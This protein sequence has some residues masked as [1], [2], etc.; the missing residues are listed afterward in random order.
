MMTAY[1]SGAAA[2]IVFVEGTDVSFFNADQPFKI[3]KSDI[4]QIS[5]L[6][7]NAGDV[8]RVQVKLRHDA[9]PLLLEK[10]DLDRGLQLLDI[11]LTDDDEVFREEAIDLLEGILKRHKSRIR[12]RDFVLAVENSELPSEDDLASLR[13]RAPNY[14]DFLEEIKRAQVHI[15]RFQLALDRALAAL[16]VSPEESVQFRSMAIERGAF[17]ALVTAGNDERLINQA[18]MLC[19]ERLKDIQQARVIIQAW[20]RDVI[21]RTTRGEMRKLERELEQY[22][23]QGYVPKSASDTQGYEIYRHVRQQQAVIVDKMRQGALR[24]ASRFADQLIRLQVQSGGEAYAAKTLSSLAVEARKLGQRSLELQWA[25]TSVELMPHDGKG[26]GVLADTYL[27]LYRIP[28]AEEAF[29]KSSALGEV[30]FGDVG[31]GRVRKSS[32]RFDEAL[33]IFK[34][35][36]LKFQNR[37][38]PETFMAYADTLREMWRETE[39]LE[40]YKTALN[41]FPSDPALRCGEAAVWADLGEHA[42]AARIYLSVNISYGDYAAAWC[43]LAAVRKSQGEFGAA[44][45]IYTTAKQKFPSNVVAFCGYADTLRAQGNYNEALSAYEE[46]SDRFPFSPSPVSGFADTLKD[47]RR[48]DDALIYL[49]EANEKFPLNARLRNNYANALKLAGFFEESLGHF[50]R[51]ARDFPYDL[52]SLTG[53]AHLLRLLGNYSAAL[54]AY[55]LIIDRRPGYKFASNA[56]ASILVAQ[57]EYGAAI[58]MLELSSPKTEDDWVTL[59]IRGMLA[60][61]CGAIDEAEELLSLGMGCPFFRQRQ[62]FETAYALLKLKQGD[63]AAADKSILSHKDN[64]SVLLHVHILL[65]K[66]E[67]DS[68]RRRYN[69]V[70]ASVPNPV[71]ELMLRLKQELLSSAPMAPHAETWLFEREA[72]VILQA[73]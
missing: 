41:R 70:H 31:I 72:E 30:E 68:A 61:R 44:L 16:N 49:R 6:L 57:G 34:A 13:N 25:E 45:E 7:L 38:S 19:Y 33:A 20:T 69:F 53:R 22:E 50:D 5:R 51:N 12:I 8:E 47:M 43:G 64:I 59:H 32:G 4:G 62:A 27:D 58:K 46:A 23:R 35:A 37:T 24:E 65:K 56:K 2:R 3:L 28:E 14:V 18:I 1:V 42:E 48:F 63:L 39:A 10:I 52:F 9:V 73:A 26:V 40:V 17:S 11:A 67:T 29:K 54:E 66:G 36:V 21:H 60:L 55:D 15:L 71:H